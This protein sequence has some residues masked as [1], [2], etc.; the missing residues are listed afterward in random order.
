MI[1]LISQVPAPETS[2]LTENATQSRSDTNFAQYLEEEQKRLAGLFLN[3]PQFNF[4]SWFTEPSS[5]SP[6]RSPAIFAD[7]PSDAETIKASSTDNALPKTEPNKTA[8]ET[9]LGYS[10]L[11]M[12]P[13]K[14]L[15]NILQ[16][17]G[18]LVPN[19][20]AQPLFSQAQLSGKL[21]T[22]LDLQ[23]L[24]DEIVNRVNLIREK[25]KTEFSFGLKS[26]NLGEI[27]I[28]LASR[29]DGISVNI[30][31]SAETKKLLDEQLSQLALALKKAKINVTEIIVAEIK[32]EKNHA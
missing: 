13:K 20:Q 19:L 31:A 28:T 12:I 29:A 3:W 25:G 32:E 22:S 14:T 11:S 23:S 2:L 5:S 27:L 24:V 17:T 4:D 21:L 8:A 15:Q 16:K 6:D 10:L 1:N 26:G 7:L 9:K 30:Q 18:W